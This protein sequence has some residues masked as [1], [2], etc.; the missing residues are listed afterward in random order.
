MLLPT[1][2]ESLEGRT[3]NNTVTFKASRSALVD[4]FCQV[5]EDADCSVVHDLLTKVMYQYLMVGS[6]T[7]DKTPGGSRSTHISACN[8]MTVIHQASLPA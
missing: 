4:L 2:D 5:M 1:L 7:V 8:R 3:E 6:A